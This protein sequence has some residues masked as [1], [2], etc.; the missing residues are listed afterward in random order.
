MYLRKT[1]LCERQRRLIKKLH[2]YRLWMVCVNLVYSLSTANLLECCFVRV[3]I[4]LKYYLFRIQWVAD[5]DLE[6]DTDMYKSNDSLL[7]FL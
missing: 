5:R 2:L 4:L 6:I 1:R 3:L 7:N